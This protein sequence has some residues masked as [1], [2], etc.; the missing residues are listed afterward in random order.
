MRTIRW[1]AAGATMLAA[2]ALSAQTPPAFDEAKIRQHIQTLSSNA[3][4]GRGPATRGEQM[5][6]D[7]LVAQLKAAG[8]QLGGEVVNGQRQWTQRVPLLKSD[9]TGTPH[10]EFTTPAGPM[11]MTQGEQIAVRAP[12]NGQTSVALNNVPM[13]FAGY[14]VTAPERQWNDFKDVDVR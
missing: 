7:Y 14:G 13:V 3:F 9:I 10:L 8:V 4:E 1:L 6:V 2:A 11:A 12:L 5:T